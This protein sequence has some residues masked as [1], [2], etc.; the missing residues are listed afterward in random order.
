[1]RYKGL[2]ISETPLIK[3]MDFRPLIEAHE[4]EVKIIITYSIN[5]FY[6]NESPVLK[7]Y[8]I[9]NSIK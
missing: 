1:M 5:I 7:H 2:L 4:Y 3:L 9:L 8:Y 6:I